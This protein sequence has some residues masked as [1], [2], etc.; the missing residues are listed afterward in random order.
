M[1]HF[2]LLSIG[3]VLISCSNPEAS[4]DNENQAEDQRP[5]STQ[6]NDSDMPEQNTK[7]ENSELEEAHDRTVVF[8]NVENLFDTEDDPNTS[9]DDFTPDGFKQWDE[10]RYLKKI[11]DLSTVLSSISDDNPALI[12]LAEIEN[13]KVLVD[14]IHAP[15]LRGKNY[16]IVHEESPD[17]RGI[18]V[19]LLIDEDVFKY[20]YHESIRIDFPWD[21]D[22]KTRDILHVV[23]HF[24]NNDKVHIFVNHWPSRRDGIPETEPKR[25]EVAGRLREK[26][27]DIYLD[28]NDPKIIVM[29]DFNDGPDN[30]SVEYVLNCMNTNS[31]L[32]GQHDLK[33]D[34]LMN[35]SYPHLLSIDFK[36][37]ELGT[38]VHD[39][40]W[41]ILDQMM[42]SQAALLNKEGIVVESIGASIFNPDW[43][44]YKRKD[45]SSTPNKTYGGPKYYGGY[46]DHLPVYLTLKNAQ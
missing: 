43:I 39:G 20:E 35:L 30:K 31:V 44:L 41:E 42:C 25:L 32:K 5:D 24:Q 18:D 15:K 9:D 27:D 12:G 11:N 40:Q 45:G 34:Q 16:S 21:S 8:Y 14:L 23:G 37:N 36:H 28:E 4:E 1:K 22:I 26:L 46:S 13:K 17:N 10:T 3:L 29:G 19:A 33:E 2:Y 7:P 6:H 38:L